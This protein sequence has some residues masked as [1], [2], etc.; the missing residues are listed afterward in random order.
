MTTSAQAVSEEKT[1]L[2][3]ARQPILTHDE[4][5]L[6]YEVFLGE[7]SDASS[8]TGFTKIG[9]FSFLGPPIRCPRGITTKFGVRIP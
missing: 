4:K 3:L 6:G 1:A 5:V 2:C 8:F 9:N 7:P